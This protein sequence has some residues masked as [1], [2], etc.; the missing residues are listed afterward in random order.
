MS[1]DAMVWLEECHAERTGGDEIEFD[2]DST[3]FPG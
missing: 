2:F 3:S 1:D